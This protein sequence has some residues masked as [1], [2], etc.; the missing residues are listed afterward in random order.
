MKCNVDLVVGKASRQ[1]RTVFANL[2]E[3]A[4]YKMLPRVSVSR[5]AWRAK[6]F[7]TSTR[8][9][10]TAKLFYTR[11]ALTES[12]TEVETHLLRYRHEGCS[13]HDLGFDDAH[14]S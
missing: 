4:G 12:S 10:W 5:D 11:S 2:S 1:D 9:F 6:A 7:E 14:D 8:L 13:I 3:L